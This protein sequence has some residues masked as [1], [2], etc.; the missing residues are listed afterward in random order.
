MRIV[1][2][3]P[4]CTEWL[5]AFDALEFLAAR[6]H[7]CNYPPSV[8][9]RPV[10]TSSRIKAT[11]SRGIYNEMM[12]RLE[13][14]MGEFE[15][16]IDLIASLEPDL[17]L[18]NGDPHIHPD[19][20]SDFEREIATRC[21]KCPQIFSMRPTTFKQVLNEALRLG[22]VI[23]RAPRAMTCIATLE[24]R[25][26]GL[27]SRL[28]I[29]KKSSSSDLPSV[30]CFGWIDPIMTSGYWISDM[31]ALAGG[32]SVVQNAGGPPSEVEWE[33][34]LRADPDVLAIIPYGFD[35]EKTRGE[36]GSLMQRPG[37]RDLKAVRTGHVFVFDG[38]GCFGRPGPR[39]YRGIEL[40]AC[41]LHPEKSECEADEWEMENVRS[42]LKPGA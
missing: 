4:G 6:S 10:A 34:V 30:A 15:I 22:S 11:T 2:L 19:L 14:E 18:T 29:R 41:T 42:A 23:G 36:L 3:E 32:R 27:Q 31:V 7:A 24:R 5:V 20:P 26:A 37:W 16:D 21:G 17:I 25:L 35:L 40:L 38:G 12:G 33:A 8:T 13:R 9:D 39:L 28:G 1:S